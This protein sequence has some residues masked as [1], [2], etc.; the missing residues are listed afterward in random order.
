MNIR[1]FAALCGI[2]PAAVSRILNYEQKESR[3]SV[4]TYDRVRKKAAELGFRPN[5][6]AKILHTSKSNC[7][8]VIIGYPNPVNSMPLI[9][10][11][12]ECAYEHGVSLTIAACRNNPR[13]ELRAFKELLYRGVDAI[14]WHPT[15]R[16][17]TAPQK[18]LNAMLEQCTQKL[19]VVSARYDPMP[20]LF[21]LD[22]DRK[23]DSVSAARRQ[24]ALGCKKF[25][26][27]SSCY[28]CFSI[29]DSIN[30]YV[31]ALREQG[32]PEQNIVRIVLHDKRRPPDWSKLADV[33]GVWMFYVFML[34]SQVADMQM[35][36][37][38]HRL[39]VD[40]QS[41]VEDYALSQ[42]VD[43]KRA[44]GC[45][46]SDNFASLKYHLVDGNKAAR[47]ATEMAIKAMRNPGLKPYAQS[48]PLMLTPIHIEPNDVLF[49]W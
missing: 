38:T 8:G 5:Y 20:C 43:G 46:F 3:A 16:R 34:H 37:D 24:L 30:H 39:H 1:Q 19:P 11:I 29:E 44:N 32:V 7:I 33:D 22:S 26:V 47:C 25:A 10:G 41:F 28:T 31:H 42:W 35:H 21:K 14:I 12:S 40:G 15:F 17:T 49:G 23:Q 18:A 6:A 36:L 45:R 9:K 48:V 4:E 13:L 27:I 2:S